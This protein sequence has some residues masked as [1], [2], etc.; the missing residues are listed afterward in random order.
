MKTISDPVTFPKELAA[1]INA[2]MSSDNF[3]HASWDREDLADLRRHVREHYRNEQRLSCAY[4]MN[5][6]SNRAVANAP[7]EY[8]VPKSLYPHFM[9]EPRNLCVIC[10]DCNEIKRDQEVVAPLDPLLKK[11]K[12]YPA[13]SS[14]FRIV[15]PHFDVYEDHIA[16]AKRIYIPLSEKGNWTIYACKLNRFY[17]RFGKC[18]ELIDDIEVIE[19]EELFFE[20][21]H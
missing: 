8:I 21:G 7:I 5:P 11:R 13:L 10:A 17:M 4:C 18:E 6:V 3:T 1:L 16:K 15:H 19:A 20:Q 14:L 2:V 9:F 12:L